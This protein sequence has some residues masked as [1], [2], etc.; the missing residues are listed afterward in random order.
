[1]TTV[2]QDEGT[3]SVSSFCFQYLS[4]RDAGSH[5]K[6]VKY[7]FLW[8]QLSNLTQDLGNSMGFSYGALIVLCFSAQVLGCYGSLL[9]LTQGFK[10]INAVLAA[11]SIFFAVML[12]CIC[13]AA[14][15]ATQEVSNRRYYY[16]NY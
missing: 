7:K 1:L 3:S 15:F 11:A 6:I 10:V 4:V 13:S 12:F 16:Y 2:I 8:L 14:Q 9:N 5:H